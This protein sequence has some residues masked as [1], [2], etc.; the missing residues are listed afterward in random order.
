MTFYHTRNTHPLVNLESRQIDYHITK[1][2]SE[3]CQEIAIDFPQLW[4][5]GMVRR[6][7]TH[8]TLSTLYLIQV[9]ITYENKIEIQHFT[10][11]ILSMTNIEF[12]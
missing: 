6:N 10:T 5:H 11:K 4:T 12:V 3:M 1:V 9:I 7:I 8:N 2:L